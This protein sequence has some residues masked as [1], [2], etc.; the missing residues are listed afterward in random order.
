MSKSKAPKLF[1]TT[2]PPSGVMS[3]CIY[4]ER[5]TWRIGTLPD[6]FKLQAKLDGRWRLLQFDRARSNKAHAAF[7]VL[8]GQQPGT[9]QLGPDAQLR[10]PKL[11]GAA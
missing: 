6:G 8:D 3:P 10:W 11:K 5:T 7:T 1:I 9:V 4:P 2:D